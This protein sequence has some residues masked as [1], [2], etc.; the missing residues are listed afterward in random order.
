MRETETSPA[1]PISVPELYNQQPLITFREPAYLL[2]FCSSSTSAIVISLWALNLDM[3]LSNP[4]KEFA[5]S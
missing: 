3:S 2:R 1:S 5:K 4:V